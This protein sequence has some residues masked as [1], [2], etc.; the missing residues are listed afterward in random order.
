MFL[1]VALTESWVIFITRL[2]Q[3]A[4]GGPFVWPSWQLLGAVFGVDILASFFALFGW[5]SG[6]APH[7]GWT[8]IVTV[9]RIW[10]FSFGVIVVVTFA[11]E[12]NQSSIMFSAHCCIQTCCSTRSHGSTELDAETY[13]GMQVFAFSVFLTV[14]SQ[15]SKKNEKLENFMTELQ[16]MTFVHEGDGSPG[17]DH[18][19]FVAGSSSPNKAAQEDQPGKAKGEEAKKGAQAAKKSDAKPP[20]KPENKAERSGSVSDTETATVGGEESKPE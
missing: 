7:N 20:G 3:D 17:S 2:S 5:I 19:R 8:S 18:Y 15:R 12:Y 1:E 6:S 14:V 16:R 10:L 13:V 9:V 4:D 11:C